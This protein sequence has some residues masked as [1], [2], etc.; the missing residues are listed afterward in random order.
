MTVVAQG[1]GRLEAIDRPKSVFQRTL[2][3]TRELAITQFKLKYTGSALGYM[4][5]LVKPLLLFGIMY[6]VFSVLLKT[7]G[8]DTDFPVELLLGIVIWTFFIE[9]TTLAMNAIAGASDLIRK[10]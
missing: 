5:S 2:N 1:S 8:A 7:G 6:L 3:L 10:A 9:S 4:W